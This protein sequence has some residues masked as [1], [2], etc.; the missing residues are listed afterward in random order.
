[1]IDTLSTQNYSSN[2]VQISSPI[3][4]QQVGRTFMVAIFVLGAVAMA[5]LGAVSWALMSKFHPAPP[6]LTNVAAPL[7]TG[8]ATTTAPAFNDPFAA[9]AKTSPA[10]VPEQPTAALP[11]PTPIAQTS[12]TAE[13]HVNDLVAQARASRDQSGDTSTAITQLREALNIA[14]ESALVI[15]ELAITYEKMGL[16]QKALEQWRRIYDMGASAGIY[17][18]A[19]DAKLKNIELTTRSSAAAATQGSQDTNIQP[20]SVLGMVNPEIVEQADPAA[21]KK[22]T[23]KIPL[24]CRPNTHIDVS[25]VAIQVFFYDQLTDESIVQTNASVSYHWST[26]PADWLEDDIE[27]L[28]VDYTQPKPDPAKLAENRTFYG[29]IIRVYYKKELQDVRADPVALLK[30]YP[31]PLTLQGAE[32][33]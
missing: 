16:D 25:N 5:E 3:P 9:A 12:P 14:P 15:S 23:L 21:Q 11:K 8:G 7:P 13:S 29:Y 17:F 10:P 22:F 24:K 19:A 1:M 27:I 33:Q 2:H 31:P 20:G 4:Q 6:D 28:E 32:S 18:A 26:L 30:K